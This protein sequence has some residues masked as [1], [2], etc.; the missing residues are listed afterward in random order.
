MS[1]NRYQ[2]VSRM[3][4]TERA[5][6]EANRNLDIARLASLMVDEYVAIRVIMGNRRNA[7]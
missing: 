5:G 2:C 3:D 6:I 4:A 7:G 1:S